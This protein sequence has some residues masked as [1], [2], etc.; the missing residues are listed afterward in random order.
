MLLGGGG[1]D[2]GGLV[3]KILEWIPLEADAEP[4]LAMSMA[5]ALGPTFGLDA[6]G[7][8]RAGETA[9]CPR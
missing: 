4:G 2:F 6:E 3:H 1:R 7:A 8:R 9:G 5:A